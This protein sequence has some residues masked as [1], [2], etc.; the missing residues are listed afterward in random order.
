MCVRAGA[1][2]GTWAALE[3][4]KPR[5]WDLM[6]QYYGSPSECL[7]AEI[8]TYGGVSK[9]PSVADFDDQKP[10]YLSEYE[11]ILFLDG[12]IL[13]DTTE[14]DRL[15]TL[16]SSFRLD[17]AQPG[18]THDS[19][20]T[21]PVT[22]RCPAFTLRF[23]N[24]VEV[25]GPLFSRDGLRQ[26]IETFR[27]SISGWGLDMVWPVIMGNP[28]D[29]IGIIDAVSM[30]HPRP[31]DPTGGEFYRYLR[32]ISVDPNEEMERLTGRFGVKGGRSYA[33]RHYGAILSPDLGGHRIRFIEST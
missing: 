10:G 28:E 31:V 33:F 26:C 1:S 22:L 21:W 32:S 24:F 15:F 6:L 23:T 4:A 12:D 3:A 7:N 27:Y 9:F 20:A 30:T 14:L 11:A 17:L 8:V 19:Y 13:V 18:L 25:M 2:P 5:A 29:R 16:F